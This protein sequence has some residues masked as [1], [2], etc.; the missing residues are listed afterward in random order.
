MVAEHQAVIQVLKPPAKVVHVRRSHDRVG[1]A[2]YHGD[3]QARTFSAEAVHFVPDRAPARERIPA[4]VTQ[5]DH[6]NQAV[7]RPVHHAESLVIAGWA[8]VH[9]GIELI[10]CPTVHHLFADALHPFHHTV[11]LLVYHLS[12]AACAQVAIQPFR[13]RIVAHSIR[14][15]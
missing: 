2:V 10:A 7:L 6:L 14:P 12:H 8:T 13:S 3:V 11:G 15:T 9:R 5:P 4:K 1:L